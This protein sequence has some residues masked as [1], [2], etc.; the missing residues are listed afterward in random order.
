MEIEEA[1]E[2]ED[3]TS[4][5]RTAEEVQSVRRQLE[6][7]EQELQKLAGDDFRKTEGLYCLHGGEM[8]LARAKELLSATRNSGAEKTSE[9]VPSDAGALEAILFSN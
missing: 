4:I 7:L 2:S 8:S 5:A 6:E 9:D 3:L 1:L